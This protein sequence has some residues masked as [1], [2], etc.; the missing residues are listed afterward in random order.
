MNQTTNTTASIDLAQLD[1]LLKV[2]A[3]MSNV[4]FN[5]AQR[6]G[7]TLTGD[8]VATMDSLRQQWDATRRSLTSGAPAEPIYQ[9]QFM[10]DA[11]TSD[12]WRDVTEAGYD[13]FPPDSR[14]IV[15]AAALQEFGDANKVDPI[16]AA[17]HDALLFG[18]GAYCKH[19]D[20]R[21]EYIDART[22]HIITAPNLDVSKMVA[23]AQ[24]H[25][26][27][28]PSAE[29]ARLLAD[30]AAFTGAGGM[31]SVNEMVGRAKAL[32]GAGAAAK[33]EHAPT[34]EQRALQI[35]SISGL[36]GA[37]GYAAARRQVDR[38]DAMHKGAVGVFAAIKAEHEATA[39][40][41]GSDQA[42]DDLIRQLRNMASVTVQDER[43]LFEAWA[44][45]L[46][47]LPKLPSGGERFYTEEQ[48]NFWYCWQS[49]RA[50]HPAQDGEK[51]AQ[52]QAARD[53]MAER[54][55][56]VEAEGWTC[57]H[58]DMHGDGQMA[59]AAGY[60]A[61]ACGYPGERDIA[62]GHVPQYWPWAQSWW[63]P[64]GARRNLV[65]AGALILAEIERLDR[66]AMAAAQQD[67]KGEQR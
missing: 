42:H 9:A 22:V 11:D 16:A 40:G 64:K 46:D 30:L 53:V 54:R 33:T 37:A 15:Y 4:M 8:H 49:A 20:G 14:R 18:T 56:Q 44:S 38:I 34:P 55:R 43:A 58:D 36:T 47:W 3:Q 21:T 27:A 66:T 29:Q 25:D 19:P 23:T 48:H 2:G 45:D 6:P 26:A 62:R 41:A 32:V 17:G 61:L 39:A 52:T 59:V 63:K 50:A 31:A 57:E 13:A 28:A 35:S 67:A 7:D 12:A 65:K 10:G 51:D 24:V 1:R 60:Y 5:L